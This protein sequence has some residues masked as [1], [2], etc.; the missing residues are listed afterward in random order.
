MAGA[1][2]AFLGGTAVAGLNFWLNL[3]ALKKD[4]STLTRLYSLRQILNVAYL[5]GV[6]FLGRA[7]SRELAPLLLGAALG[8]TIPAFFFAVQHSFI[9]LLWDPRHIIYR[10]LSFLPL[11]IILCWYYHKKRDPL[12]IMVGHAVIDLATAVE[13]LVMS[14]DPGYYEKMTQM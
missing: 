6:F 2:L 3:R 4:P 12:P 1:V 8:L 11:T 13:I 7:V 9:P 5:A 10:F 14:V